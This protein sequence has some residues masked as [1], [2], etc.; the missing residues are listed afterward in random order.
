MKIPRNSAQ[1]SEYFDFVTI[2][3]TQIG[4][5]LFFG[6]T[7]NTISHAGVVS[8]IDQG[9]TITF[10][11]TSS[12]LGVIE[13]LRGKYWTSKLQIIGRPDYEAAEANS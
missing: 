6:S 13:E 4:D 9:K 12:S 5:I 11:H 8:N 3:D 7:K 1:Q 10:I 2:S